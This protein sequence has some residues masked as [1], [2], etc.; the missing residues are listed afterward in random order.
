M[1]VMIGDIIPLLIGFFLHSVLLLA[2]LLVMIKVQKFNYNWP[3]L[4]GAAFLAGG[5]DM[6]PYAGHLLAI[7]ILYFCIW[8][9]T[10]SSLFPDAAFTV[11]LSYALMT[12]L[13]WVLLTVETRGFHS[14]SNPEDLPPP[15]TA[16]AT[17]D[18][19]ELAEAVSAPSDRIAAGILIKGLSRGAGMAMVTLQYGAKNYVISH[20]EAV[21]IST[22]EGLVTVRFLGVTNNEVTLAVRGQP[23]KY[24][25]K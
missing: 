18:T 19:N 24:A 21:S 6:V 3:G 16:A 14:T 4:V 12:C 23:V 1:R 15:S 7:P 25:L 10:N 2:F 5:L 8:K 22:E 11:V 20:G 17:M 13:S 9:I